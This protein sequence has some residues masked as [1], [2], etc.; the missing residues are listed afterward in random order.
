MGDPG[1][2]AGPQELPRD[3]S[4]LQE[5]QFIENHMIL[6]IYIGFKSLRLKMMPQLKLLRASENE[7]F[8]LFFNG[9]CV[10]SGSLTGF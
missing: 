6:L 1:G 4:I 9:F 7:E 3:P 8:H 10:L 5:M 2:P